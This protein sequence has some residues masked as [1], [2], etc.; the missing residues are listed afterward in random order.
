MKPLNAQR[1]LYTAFST[2]RE[3]I[4]MLEELKEPIDAIALDGKWQQ[5]FAAYW[6]GEDGQQPAGAG[7]A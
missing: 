1:T 2:G 3:A 7:R 6:R 5:R 4:P